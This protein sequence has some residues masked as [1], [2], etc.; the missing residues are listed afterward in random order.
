LLLAAERAVYRPSVRRLYVADVHFGKAAAFRGRGVPVPAGT[1]RENLARLD[2][3][4]ADYAPIELVFLG[5]FAHARVAGLYERLR[6]WR[7][8]HRDVG[9]RIVRGNHDARAGEPPGEL[10]IELIELLVGP[11]P[12]PPF[13]LRHEPSQSADGFG[14]AGHLH[15]CFSLHGRAHEALRLPCFWLNA[16]GL[17]LPAFGAFTGGM[18]IQPLEQD[19]VF[20]I[21]ETRVLEVGPRRRAMA[22]GG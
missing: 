12:D 8:R 1:T 15:P 10:G 5:D 18:E 19:R 9:M 14:L 13:V 22:K 11:S 17:V 16:S 21:A 7:E 4:I 20:V 2:G 6:P 3:L